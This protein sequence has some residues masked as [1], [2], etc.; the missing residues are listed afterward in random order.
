MSLIPLRARGTTRSSVSGKVTLQRKR[1]VDSISPYNLVTEQFPEF[2]QSDYPGLV[3][4]AKKY[5]LYLAQT[6]NGKIQDIKDIDKTSGDYILR[7]RK[8]FSYN[9][10][11]FNFLSEI[12]FEFFSNWSEVG[13]FLQTS[14]NSALR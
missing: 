3:E 11:K 2:I 4:F 8:E 14:V 5:F 10:A 1:D 13:P 9:S 6:E 12:L 7:L